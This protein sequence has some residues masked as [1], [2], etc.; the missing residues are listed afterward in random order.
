MH[1]LVVIGGG[2]AGLSAA[3]TA[4]KT[5]GGANVTLITDEKL[6]YSPCS[7]PFVIGGEIESLDKITN[8]IVKICEES[9]I[10]CVLDTVDSVDVAGKLVRTA[11][12]VEFKYTSLIIAVGGVPCVPPIS[13]AG[14]EGVC[15]LKT[16][17]DARKIMLL[18]EKAENAVV[19]GGGAIGLEMAVA[20][21]KRGL[22]VSLIERSEHVLARSLDPDFSKIVEDELSRIGV[23]LVFCKD[24]LEICGEGSVQGVRLDDRTIPADIILLGVGLR[25]NIRLAEKIGLE[26]ICGGIKTDGMMQTS[27]ND[28]YAVG[29]C[30]G[31]KSM[32][33][34][35]FMLSQLG[36]TAMRHGMIA[37]I[38]AVGGY[39]TSEGVLNSMILK[40]SDLEIGRTGLTV[41]DAM[42]NG[43]D[44]VVGKAKGT[45]KA[46]YFPGTKTIEL[47]L[48]FDALNGK[49]IGAQAAGE[50][51]VAGKIDL[52]AF[53]I[54]HNTE[55]MDLMKLKYCYTPAVTPSRN[56]IVLA[57]E[58]ALRNLRRMIEVRKRR[59]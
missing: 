2:G 55:I 45:T 15:T 20:F 56:L 18:L 39:A 6:S 16:I 19:V 49:V 29:D 34:G 33:T 59:F 38:N 24:V 1:D 8:D 40:I 28:I 10:K 27:I 58:N 17:E 44:V 7:L 11:G 52:I 4:K 35:K 36:T 57:A 13:G 50:K 47:K 3:L 43:I 14:L 22:K 25:A 12:G 48:V 37:G 30:V 41:R 51:G 42:E 32:V 31:S 26:T 23:E 5:N 53:A 21:I 46:P 9:G 54:A